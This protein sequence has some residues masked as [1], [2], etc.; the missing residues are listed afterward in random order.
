MILLRACQQAHCPVKTGR[1]VRGVGGRAE[2][3]AGGGLR[4]AQTGPVRR[5][6]VALIY[7]RTLDFSNAGMPNE[8]SADILVG[9]SAFVNPKPTGMPAC[10]ADRSALQKNLRC[11]SCILPTGSSL[12]PPCSRSDRQGAAR[13]SPVAF[14]RSSL[15]PQPERTGFGGERRLGLA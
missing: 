7:V 5:F 1:A 13:R 11:A 6:E 8:W 4:A 3:G 15:P 10:L 2:R 9:L 14:A 12:R